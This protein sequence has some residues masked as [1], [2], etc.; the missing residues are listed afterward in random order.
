MKNPS[1]AMEIVEKYPDNYRKNIDCCN[2]KNFN[3][4]LPVSDNLIE[5]QDEFMVIFDFSD[6]RIDE[7]RRLYDEYIVFERPSQKMRVGENNYTTHLFK[8]TSLPVKR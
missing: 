5:E 4:R 2:C 1:I 6:N 8:L 7:F 3:P